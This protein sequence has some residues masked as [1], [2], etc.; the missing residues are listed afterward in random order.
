MKIVLNKLNFYVIDKV[1]ICYLL[2]NKSKEK[3]SKIGVN[4]LFSYY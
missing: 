3:L 1:V 2:F 4:V